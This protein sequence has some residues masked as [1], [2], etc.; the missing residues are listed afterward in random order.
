MVSG[1]EITCVS[2]NYAGDIIRIS[3][4]GWSLETRDA[5]VQILNKQLRLNI[6]VDGKQLDVGLRGEGFNTYLATEPDGFPLH[7]LTDLPAC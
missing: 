4:D 5:I 1:L 2:K 6:R 7:K 3:G